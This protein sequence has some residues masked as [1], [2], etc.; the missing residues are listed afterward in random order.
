MFPAGL[1]LF[2]LLLAMFHK[3]E[4][5][6]LGIAGGSALVC[7]ISAIVMIVLGIGMEIH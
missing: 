2:Y 4:I 7:W 6:A 3:L 5:G 1:V